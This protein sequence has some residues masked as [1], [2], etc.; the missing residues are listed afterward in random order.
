MTA[1]NFYENSYESSV[2]LQILNLFQFVTSLGRKF[3]HEGN[4]L[5]I[6]HDIRRNNGFLLEWV[7]AV[8]QCP[9][10]YP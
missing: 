8:A 10:E 2:T 5:M 6:Q 3:H 4:Q 1:T 9:N 7:L